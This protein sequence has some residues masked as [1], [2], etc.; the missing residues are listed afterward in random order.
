MK[1]HLS[2][3]LLGVAAIGLLTG[4]FM[5]P[6]RV[7]PFKKEPFNISMLMVTELIGFGGGGGNVVSVTFI[8]TTAWS[9]GASISASHNI[10][11]FQADLEVFMVCTGI[12]ITGL[13]TLTAATSTVAGVAVTKATTEESGSPGASFVTNSCAFVSPGVGGAQTC[14][15]T[16]SRTLTAGNM[17]I[18][19]VTGRQVIAAQQT[20]GQANQSSANNNVTLAA[21]TVNAGGFW[22]SSA[23]ANQTNNI[24][25]TGPTIF[26]EDTDTTIGTSRCATYSDTPLTVP[27]PGGSYTLSF[28]NGNGATNWGAAAWAFV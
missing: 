23:V 20:A 1:K 7:L 2:K 13:A 19:R 10:G 22:L 25:L 6:V 16:F 5:G 3:I 17:A 15:A 28:N 26:T 18:Y 9:A 11:T 12:N 14:T 21:L 8:G 24:T 4:V 27:E